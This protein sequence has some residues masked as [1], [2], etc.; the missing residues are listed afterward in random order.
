MILLGFLLAQD[1]PVG[2]LIRSLNDDDI[3]VRRKA[4]EELLRRGRSAE[5]ALWVA[6]LRG[7]SLEASLA[8]EEILSTL[9]RLEK[10]TRA[11]R[12]L[13]T[14]RKPVWADA[15]GELLWKGRAVKVGEERRFG[16]LKDDPPRV[17]D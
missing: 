16:K 8:A 5:E 2:D 4:G 15:D 11:L 12:E 17:D 1:A 13:L 9:G 10:G 14:G 7:E 6:M 3:A